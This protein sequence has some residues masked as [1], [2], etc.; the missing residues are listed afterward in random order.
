MPPK[1]RRVQSV[2]AAIL[3]LAVVA[4]AAGAATSSPAVDA[5]ERGALI[6]DLLFHA[7]FLSALDRLCPVRG[8]A[9]DWHA[10]LSD[11]LAEAFTPD[12]RELSQRLGADAGAQLVRERGGCHTR[13]F[14]A[15][16]GE[17]KVEYRELLQRWRA[18]GD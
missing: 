12:L 2:R 16:Y 14:A 10:G 3:W 7:D 11:L 5:E 9:G 4:G 18:L 13:D 15:A 17:S 8:A 6:G 1:L